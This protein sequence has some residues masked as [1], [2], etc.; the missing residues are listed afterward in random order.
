M[1]WRSGSG[2]RATGAQRCYS[3]TCTKRWPTAYQPV[4]PKKDT[5]FQTSS[6]NSLPS[7]P[8]A[9]RSTTLSP[10][11]SAERP[12]RVGSLEFQ[13][14]YKLDM[15]AQKDY[16]DALY[17]HEVAEPSLN[18]TALERHVTKLGVEDEYEQPR[19]S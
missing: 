4:S 14:A 18:R 2:R 7:N 19:E 13:I 11:V 5:E 16:E 1:S 8:T 15:G 3:T 17:L 6:S 10:S 9:S 12:L